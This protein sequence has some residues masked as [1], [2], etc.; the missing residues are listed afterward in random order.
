MLCIYFTIRFCSI[1]HIRGFCYCTY[2]HSQWI[3]MDYC[4]LI[5]Q[6]FLFCIYL[7]RLNTTHNLNMNKER[8]SN[9]KYMWYNV[10]IPMWVK[11]RP[12][13]VVVTDR[14]LLPTLGYYWLHHSCPCSTV[15]T[16]RRHGFPHSPSYTV[17]LLFSSQKCDYKTSYD[18]R[19]RPDGRRNCTGNAK[20]KKNCFCFG[21][22][23]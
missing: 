9:C 3:D 13:H 16:Y 22:L 11:G 23:A 5:K 15:L 2:I 17:L 7:E 8:I 12:S 1:A 21:Y 18:H 14:E 19:R 4:W 6:I 10:I 20:K